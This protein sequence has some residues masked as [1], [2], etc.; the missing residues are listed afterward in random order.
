MIKLFFSFFIAIGFLFSNI[1]QI[2]IND[3]DYNSIINLPIEDSSKLILIAEFMMEHGQIENIYE[4]LTIPSI[5]STEIEQLKPFIYVK[6]DDLTTFKNRLETNTFDYGNFLNEDGNMSNAS[7]YWLD[8]VLY[9][10]DINDLGYYDLINLPIL[11]PLDVASV[12]KQKSNFEIRSDFVLKNADG[13]SRYGLKK[14]RKFITYPQKNLHPNQNNT[15]IHVDVNTRPRT[16]GSDSESTEFKNA[17]ASIPEIYT[18]IRTNS[19]NNLISGVS[20]FRTMGQPSLNQTEFIKSKELKAYIS[21]ENIENDNIFLDKLIIGNF[22]ASYGQG[23]VFESSDDFRSR[24][25]GYGWTKRQNGIMPD[26]SKTTQFTLSG[27]GVQYSHPTLNI[28]GFVSYSPRDAIIN[29]DSSF[30]SLITLYPRLEWGLSGDSTLF[31]HSLIN[32]VNE[33]TYGGHI[34]I[35]PTKDLRFGST[36][37]ESLYD[38]VLNSDLEYIKD[39]IIEDDDKLFEPGNADAEISA[40]YSSSGESSLWDEAKSYRRVLGFDFTYNLENI[41]FQGEYGELNSNDEIYKLGDEPAA[42]IINSYFKF[43]KLDV[44][45]L[46]RDYDLEYDN[47]YQRSFSN[48]QRYKNTLFSYDY[49]LIDPIYSYLHLTNAQPQAE[50]GLYIYS[51]YEF[52]RNF[53]ATLDW[54]TWTRVAD[55]ARYY[56]IRGSIKYSPI[57]NYFIKVSQK[58]QAKSPFNVFSK[59]NYF[60]S[61]T[62]ITAQLK[63]SNYNNIRLSYLINRYHGAPRPSLVDHYDGS[64]YQMQVGDAGFPEISFGVSFTHHFDNKS[65]LTGAVYMIDGYFLNTTSGDFRIFSDSNQILFTNVSAD[66]WVTQVLKVNFK[67][68]RTLN[69]VLTNV[70]GVYPEGSDIDSNPSSI[71][72]PT[73]YEN[74]SD[75]TLQV[76]YVF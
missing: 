19:G 63:L 33:F 73:I 52:H 74:S 58:F 37:Y 44:L 70:T 39:T 6:S 20:Y 46:Y 35:F 66:V 62:N 47:A 17:N 53:L 22:S 3:A 54:D 12:L 76:D 15:R 68:S 1:E 57:F 2:N 9:P 67:F 38:R 16:S 71:S 23:V 13:I 24:R 45:V 34:D 27:I 60:I 69:N 65:T 18:T 61:E 56:R 31:N 8:M 30:A 14:L 36:F 48:Y 72:Y 11:S 42:W 51:R 10:E 25:S 7:Q 5:T 28:S 50:K 41:T 75:F 29:S 26:G 49:R 21:F 59:K 55:K 32:S 4:L 40:M 64:D 43:D